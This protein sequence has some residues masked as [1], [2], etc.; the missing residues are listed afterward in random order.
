[1]NEPE[2]LNPTT[3]PQA[4]LLP[5]YLAD[6][7]DRQERLDVETHLHHCEACQTE[8]QEMKQTKAALKAAVSEREG[9]SSTVLT[10]V[11]ARIR[12]EKASTPQ[13]AAPVPLHDSSLWSQIG[14]WLQSLFAVPWVPVFATI[15]IIG[16]SALLLTNLDGNPDHIDRGPVISRGIPQSSSPSTQLQVVFTETTTQGEIQ[17]LLLPLQA[18]IISGP[19][20]DGA[21]K[22][23]IPTNDPSE[24]RTSLEAL[25]AQSTIIRSATSPNP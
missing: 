15:L 5:W 12:E 1:M 23:K 2:A 9:P 16:Q 6:T 21:Y 3:H 18:Q 22:L 17:A 14:E 24:I 19:S 7:L 8:L 4:A 25:R 20:T 11:M 10:Q 13:A